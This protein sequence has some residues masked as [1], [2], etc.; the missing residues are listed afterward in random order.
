MVE[1]WKPVDEAR[2]V[3]VE[4]SKAME[5]SGEADDVR[6]AFTVE[7]FDDQPVGGEIATILTVSSAFTLFFFIYPAPLIAAA[8][9]AALALFP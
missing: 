8:D 4:L 3:G 2:A 7:G 5:L 1:P 9:S 6:V